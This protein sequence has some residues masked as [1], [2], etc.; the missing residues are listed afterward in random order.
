VKLTVAAA[1]VS[2]LLAAGGQTLP[3]HQPED[4][5]LERVEHGQ[6]PEPGGAMVSYRIRL[7]PLAAFPEL[8]PAVLAQLGHR[9]C[10]IPQ[11]FEAQAP[12]NVIEGS[13]QA[14]GSADWAALCSAGGSTTLYV[15]LAGQFDQPIALR[16]QADT[17]W[18]GTEPGGSIYGSAWGIAVLRAASLR[19]SRQIHGAASFDHDGI[20]D[21]RL[22]H[23]VTVRYLDQGKWLAL[24]SPE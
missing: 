23:G 5:N 18:L 6:I 9:R 20:E 17:A 15:F 19:A 24:Q 1:L 11:S 3:P 8:P 21:A 2:G 13:F 14:P 12:E 22:E 7:L 4:L 10:M 16:S